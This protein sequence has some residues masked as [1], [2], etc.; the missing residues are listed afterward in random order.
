MIV[1]LA[2]L[3]SLTPPLLWLGFFRS[4]DLYEPEPGPLLL[5]VFL[6]GMVAGPWAYGMNTLLLQVG[7]LSLDSLL[8]AYGRGASLALL[9][10]VVGLAALNEEVVKYVVVSSRTRA[11]ANFNEPV[12]GM[13]YMAAAALGF[14]ASENFIY[15]CQAYFGGPPTLAGETTLASGASGL[16]P[17]GMDARAAVQAFWVVAPL[18]AVLSTIG[19]VA[20]SGILGYAL[21]R[22]VLERAPDRVLLRGIGAAAGLHAAYDLPGFYQ[23]CGV[24]VGWVLGPVWILGVAWYIALF[25]RSLAASPFRRVPSAT[26]PGQPPGPA[27]SRTWLRWRGT[28][29]RQAV[30]MAILLALLVLCVPAGAAAGLAPSEIAPLAL[31]LSVAL[32]SFS[33][34]N[35]RCPACYRHLGFVLRLR[36]CAGC[37]TTFG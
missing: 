34:L 15:T 11:D 32:V 6:W 19:H 30:V 2:L 21:S 33:W 8:S 16:G 35:W 12:D 24:D 37:K 10:V 27:G 36:A 25:G 31:A 23:R 3:T 22:Q 4:Q 18:R 13:V 14:A 1:F 9:P 5:Q 28:S 26:G 7:A 29:S 20:W 17:I